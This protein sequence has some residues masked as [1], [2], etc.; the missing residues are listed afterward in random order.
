MFDSEDVQRFLIRQET[1][2]P[3]RLKTGVNRTIRES[4]WIIDCVS[5]DSK[6]HQVQRFL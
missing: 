3:M 5:Y 6:R 4:A 2:A 1:N